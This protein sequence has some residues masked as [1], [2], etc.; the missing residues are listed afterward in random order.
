VSGPTATAT[1]SPTPTNTPP[2]APTAAPNPYG[3][4]QPG[5]GTAG[6][7][8]TVSGGGFPPNTM[9]YAHL[10]RLDGSSGS[11]SSYAGYASAPTDGAG[12][13][14]HGLR[15]AGDVAQRQ[16]HRHAAPGDP[17]GDRRLRH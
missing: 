15:H 13:Y 6:T 1:P 9:L 8:V 17:G 14:V 10:A 4:G 7:A 3:A 12:N 2:V 11:G 16:R 5:S